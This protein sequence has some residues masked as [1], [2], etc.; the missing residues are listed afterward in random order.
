MKHSTFLYF[1]LLLAMFSLASCE[2]DNWYDWKTENEI[3]LM[4][5]ALRDSVITTHS[6]LQYKIIRDPNPTDAKPSIGK[7]VTVKYSGRLINGTVFDSGIGRFYVANSYIIQ[8]WIEG[9]SKIHTHGQIEL[10]I[11]YDLGYGEEENGT[12]GT[13]SYIPPYSTLIFTIDLQAIQ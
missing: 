11:P 4:N 7:T 6:G 8:G 5:N 3:W 10:Y 12:E 9:L 1:T 13:T 2:Q